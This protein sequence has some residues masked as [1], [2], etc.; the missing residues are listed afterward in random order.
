MQLVLFALAGVILVLG[1]ILL[2][3][4]WRK[5]LHSEYAKSLGLAL[6]ISPAIFVPSSYDSEL[7]PRVILADILV[8]IGFA[9]LAIQLILSD[10]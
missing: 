6:Y 1:S 9:C 3:C 4:A 7:R 8:L 5:N 10:F 2:M